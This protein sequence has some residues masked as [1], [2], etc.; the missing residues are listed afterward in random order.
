VAHSAGGVEAR[1]EGEA[2]GGAVDGSCVAVVVFAVAGGVDEGAE[3]GVLG[4]E[5]LGEAVLD[6]DA[7][8]AG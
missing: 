8:F 6:D 3:A 4:A 2:D 5:E 1:G 7:V